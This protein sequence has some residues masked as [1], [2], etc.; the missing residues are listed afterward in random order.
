MKIS[1]IRVFLTVCKSIMCQT[2]YR[3]AKMCNK[4]KPRYILHV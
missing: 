1:E 4:K 3:N 2:K